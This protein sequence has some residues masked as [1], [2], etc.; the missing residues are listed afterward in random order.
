MRANR[1]GSSDYK[2]SEKQE[3]DFETIK[4]IDPRNTDFCTSVKD[5]MK[6]WNMTVQWWLANY[7][8]RRA[9]MKARILRIGWTMLVSAYWHGIHPGYYLS[10]LT[11]PLCLAA[12]GAMEVG[13]RQR[14][15]ETGARLYDWAHWFL[16][17]RAYDYLCMGFVLLTFQD[18]LDFWR[19]IHY[20]IHWLALSLFLLGYA[21]SLLRGGPAAGRGGGGASGL[22]SSLLGQSQEQVDQ[23]RRRAAPPGPPV[24]IR[25]PDL[26][27]EVRLRR[28]A[29]S[30]EPEAAP[31]TPPPATPPPSNPPPATPPSSPSASKQLS[32]GK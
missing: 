2:F 6:Y 30:A 4:N 31:A 22:S 10:F 7:V 25:L 12:E 21:L 5:G 3:Y 26:P 20:Y 18:T 11:V 8:Y 16:K 19:H 32:L 1:L 17:M 15:G 27:P 29:Q 9:P 24:A 14:L 13:L 23:P 28:T